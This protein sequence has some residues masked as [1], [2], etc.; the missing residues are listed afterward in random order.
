MK[1]TEKDLISINLKFD[2][3]TIINRGALEFA[4]SSIRK[5]QDW[6][7]QIAYLLRALLS[8]HVF[9]DGNKRTAMHLLFMALERQDFGF[10][11][12]EI[13]RMIINIAKG[14]ISDIKEI[15]KI[16][17]KLIY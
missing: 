10:K 3:G 17:I 1:I 8:D 11:E 6:K 2:D 4:L 12:D 16:L 7:E 5:D 9:K 14:G 13:K 15:K